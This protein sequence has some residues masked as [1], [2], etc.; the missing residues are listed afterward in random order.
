MELDVMVKTQIEARGVKD[1]AILAAMRKVD[2]RLFVPE[3]LRSQSYFDGPLPIGECQTISQPFIVAYMTELLC[4]TRSSKTLEIGTGCGYQTAILAETA[5]VVYTIEIIRSL[6]IKAEALLKKLNYRSI[7]FRLGD[8]SEGWPENAPFDGI[9]V[10]CAP[11]SPP[12]A[13]FEQLSEGG[14]LVIPIG[15][16]WQELYVFQKINNTIISKNTIPVRFV[17]MTGGNQ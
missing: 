15:S 7:H 5:G 12:Q 8:G 11:E 10:T 1:E 6:Q 4:L 13:L 17:T 2:R 9:I 3:S 14:R 16:A